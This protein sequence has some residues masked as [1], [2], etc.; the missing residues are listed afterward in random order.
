MNQDMQDSGVSEHTGFPNAATDQ[1]LGS[2]NVASLLVRRPISTFFM[3]IIGPSAE[4][5]GIYDG[6]IVVIDRGLKVRTSDLVVW[7]QDEV[8]RVSRSKAV[9]ALTV[10]W[11][12]VTH[13]I[14]EYRAEKV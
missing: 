5:Y 10:V 13:V 4:E 14:H 2:L 7:W 1:R 6:D 12:V 11:G 9:P 8:F 3:R